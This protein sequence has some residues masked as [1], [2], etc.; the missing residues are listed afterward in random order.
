MKTTRIALI[1]LCLS[2]LT[3]MA[4][5][6]SGGSRP[7]VAECDANS[8]QVPALR[9]PYDCYIVRLSIRAQDGEMDKRIALIQAAE[10]IL[11]SNPPPILLD[12]KNARAL[13]TPELQWQGIPTT[14]Q[15]ERLLIIPLDGTV[16]TLTVMKSIA[17]WFEALTWPK[18]ISA[19]LDDEG[20]GI[21]DP[22]SFRPKLI[23]ATVQQVKDIRDAFGGKVKVRIDGLAGCVEVKK[24]SDKEA[25]L[26]IAHTMVVELE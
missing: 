11:A 7:V 20:V 21:R 8:Q 6:G 22:E 16:D 13:T 26:T 4:L 25:E 9:V 5:A 3:I 1:S 12:V 10:N 17:L 19:E 14:T 18:G 2:T 15:R 23:A 24:F